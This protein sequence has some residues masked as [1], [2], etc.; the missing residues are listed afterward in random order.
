MYIGA[1]LAACL[2][3][4][5]VLVLF[6]GVGQMIASKESVPDR[7]DTL[8]PAPL[9]QNVDGQIRGKKTG[10]LTGLM[11]RLVSAQ[12][13]SS[14]IA[15]TLARAN[16]PLTVTEYVSIH[17][18]CV[19]IMFLLAFVFSGQ[20]LL[21]LV[22]AIVGSFLPGLYVRR[23]QTQ[24][25]V[26]FQQQLTD[27][28]TLLVGSLRSGYGLTIAMDT[29]AKQMPAPASEEF[30]SVVREVGL[31]AS[32]TQALSNLVRRIRSD[33]LDLMVTAISV[34]YE[35]GG[36]LATILDTISETIR[37]RLRIKA[38]LRAMTVQHTMTRY[39]L[40][41]LPLVLG[42][43]MYIINPEY[44]G[45]LFTPGLTLAI[46]IG[47]GISLVMGYFVMSKLSVIEV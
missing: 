30:G 4:V 10:R 34:Q 29:V 7:L 2:V 23:K 37:E 6:T 9:P 3:G 36:N 43:I 35:V 24:R 38:Q 42:G 33:D 8:G 12:A 14:S 1:I 16:L 13:F 26:A 22:G 18:A 17:I 27:V 25:Q 39:I 21:G 11:S 41:A 15:T 44:M 19:A 32:V 28:L 40:T 20:P 45:N 47:A 31:G 5:A 46:P